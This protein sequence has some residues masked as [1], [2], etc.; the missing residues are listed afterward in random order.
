MYII[1]PTTSSN[2]SNVIFILCSR[3]E[4]RCLLGLDHSHDSMDESWNERVELSNLFNPLFYPY[5]FTV[6]RTSNLPLITLD[7]RFLFYIC[8]GSVYK[9]YEGYKCNSNTETTKQLEYTITWNVESIPL[10]HI[11]GN[12][13]GIGRMK[14]LY[15]ILFIVYFS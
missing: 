2:T 10:Q 7:F 5:Y 1:I 15:A 14:E 9:G 4:L 6:P 12:E 8:I 13:I 11:V 3:H